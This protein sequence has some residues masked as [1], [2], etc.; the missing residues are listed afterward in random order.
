MYVCVYNSIDDLCKMRG[1]LMCLAYFFN[2]LSNDVGA[3]RRAVDWCR[4][5]MSVQYSV[6]PVSGP[7]RHTVPTITPTYLSL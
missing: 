6:S 3:T 4:N 7:A 1:S 2:M 5:G